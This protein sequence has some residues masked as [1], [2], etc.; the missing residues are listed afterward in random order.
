M[1][2]RRGANPR[3]RTENLLLTKQLRCHCAR[4]ALV[5]P[6]RVELTHPVGASFTDWLGN[7]PAVVNMVEIQGIEP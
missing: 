7:R 4:K 3:T 6:V 5:L 1:L 2:L